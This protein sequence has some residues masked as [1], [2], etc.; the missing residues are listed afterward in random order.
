MENKPTINGET[1]FFVKLQM[2]NGMYTPILIKEDDC[3][4][5]IVFLV[6]HTKKTQNN[7]SIVIHIVTKLGVLLWEGGEKSC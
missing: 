1:P 4:D 6:F 5:P 7:S 3:W 2:G